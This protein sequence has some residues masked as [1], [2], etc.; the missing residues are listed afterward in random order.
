MEAEETVQRREDWGTVLFIDLRNFTNLL[1]FHGPSKIESVLDEVF[2]DFKRVVESYGGSVDKLIGDGMMAV[3][4][5]DRERDC[6]SNA[7]RAAGEM[8]YRRLPD[9]ERRTELDLEVGIGLSTGNLRKA[10]IADIDETIISRNV[11]IAARLQSLCKKFDVAIISDEETRKNV[12]ELPERYRFRMIPHQRIEGIYE[13]MDV[14]EICLLDEYDEMYL[15][16]YNR[17]AEHYREREYSKALEF[18]VSAYSDPD[19]KDDR[20]LLHYFA[21]ECFDQLDGAG[22]LFQNADLYEEN[23]N[24]QRTQAD[25]LLWQLQQITDRRGLTPSRILDVGC[26]SGAVTEEVAE[27]FPKAEITAIDESADQVRKANQAHPHERIT[28]EVADIVEYR[29]EGQFDIVVSNSTMHWVQ[30]Q[31]DAY[32]NVYRALEP[33]GILAVH[34]GGEGCYH[35]LHEA[36]RRAYEDLGLEGYFHDF[37]F[38]L[39]YH[40][41]DEMN[42][43]LSRNGFDPLKIDMMESEQPD[44]LVDDFAEAS[45]LSYKQRLENKVERKNLTKRYKSFARE[46][47]DIDTTRIYAFAIR[48]EEK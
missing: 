5:D 17:A 24:T 38:P 15:E 35:E 39:V 36:T 6:E 42:D 25:Y 47:D 9:L 32:Q 18:F 41:R 12:G 30:R 29:P 21:S 16:E 37:E 44:T 20:T 34:Q 45:L 14:Y 8:L 22:S 33:D 46:Y 23:S 4:R 13:Q 11:N 48:P 26:G 27:T 28:Y 40:D 31:D 43:V 2:V 7:V 1:E 10:T 3:F 19:R